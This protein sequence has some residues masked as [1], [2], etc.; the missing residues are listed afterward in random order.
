MSLT[1]TEVFGF[2]DAVS[3]AFTDNTALLLTKG[4]TAA[5]HITEIGAVK[6]TAVTKNGAQEDIK[7]AL[8]TA[9]IQTDA[10]LQDAY[11]VSSSKLDMIVG[12]V[13]K[14]TPKGQELLKLRSK[15]RNHPA[16]PPTPPPTP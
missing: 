15:I 5:P 11:N 13:G 8:K 1:T 14:T 3:Q 9:T 16:T 6:T 4:I 2:A 12:A 10:A 7:A